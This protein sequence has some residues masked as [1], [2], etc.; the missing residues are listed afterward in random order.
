[1]KQYRV[2]IIG[3]GNI[4]N[5][6]I[7]AI[8][9]TGERLDLAAIADI[10][11]ERCKAI[12]AAHNIPNYYTNATEM[13]NAVQPDLVHVITPTGTHFDLTLE[14]LKAGA[15]VYCEK[16]LC[17]SLA[18]F[19]QLAA[20]EARTGKYVS[21]VAQW[22]FGSAGQHLKRLIDAGE[23]G[24]PMV[25]LCQTLWYRALPY[26]QV[27]WRGKWATET[28]GATVTLGIHLMDLFLWLFGDWSEVRAIAATIDRP[29]EVDNVSMALVN[30][31]SGALGNIT[32][33]AVSP[34]QESF[35]RLDFERATVE[36]TAL[37][38]YTN[39][40]WRFST[41]DGSPF[42]DDLQHWQT[43][44]QDTMGS[45][46]EQLALLLDSMDRNERPSVSGAEARR[47]LE[48]IASLYKAAFT[49]QAVQRGTIRADDPF[50]YAMNGASQPQEEA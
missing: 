12:C 6:H 34:R 28:G 23:L 3:A 32:T 15:W 18:Q 2:A 31:E 16:P 46:N 8:R 27:P 33:S 5:S 10:D 39:Q 43:I 19:D 48:F 17:A 30:F 44:E 14:C 50:Y 24:R 35:L 9:S 41:F 47:I 45:H 49:G 42:G 40:N 36:C 1:M 11:A 20:A 26:Y 7:D 37:Y 21:T 4:V 29:I 38:R 13:L 25:G 22:R